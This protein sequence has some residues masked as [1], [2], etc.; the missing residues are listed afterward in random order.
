M[1]LPVVFTRTSERL[2]IDIAD[3]EARG[4]FLNGPGGGKRR[5]GL[6][7][8]FCAAVAATDRAPVSAAE[9]LFG[10]AGVSQCSW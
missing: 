2:L 4:G 1:L 3:D 6:V 8:P 5:G 9:W 7:I 10:R